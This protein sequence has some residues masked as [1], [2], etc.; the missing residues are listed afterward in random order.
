MRGKA[1]G[2]KS[3]PPSFPLGFELEL[4]GREASGDAGDG[5]GGDACGDAGGD[6]VAALGAEARL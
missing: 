2:A 4:A 6:I 5:A 3:C 1:C